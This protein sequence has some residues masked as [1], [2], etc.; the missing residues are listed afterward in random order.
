MPP[1]ASGK[2]KKSKKSAKPGWMADD[3]WAVSQD[4]PALLNSFAGIKSD[5]PSKSKTGGKSDR[6]A[7]PGKAGKSAKPEPLPNIPKAQ[8]PS[9]A[10]ILISSSSLACASCFDDASTVQP[11]LL[12]CCGP[13]HG[14]LQAGLFLWQQLLP[15][16]A[17][18]Q[19]EEL[20][21]LDIAGVSLTLLPSC[22]AV[23]I[24]GQLWHQASTWLCRTKLFWGNCIITL[25][26]IQYMHATVKQLIRS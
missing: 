11:R 16:K 20:L 5:Q 17:A 10:L 12:S 24:P 3:V 14:Y 6:P 23:S 19:R 8:V 9:E 26:I 18:A 25:N 22:I 2:P 15:K 13:H 7:T 4:L 21:K 1:K